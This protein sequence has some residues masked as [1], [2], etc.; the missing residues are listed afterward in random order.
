[1]ATV[2][3]VSVRVN[4]ILTE[5]LTGSGKWLANRSPIGPV[6]LC[7]VNEPSIGPFT[8][9]A[10]SAHLST[11]DQALMLCTVNEPLIGPFTR[12]LYSAHEPASNQAFNALH[13]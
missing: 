9:E 11:T 6:I 1:M 4:G 13:S 8:N 12:K 10:I 7:T 3:V 2:N 5:P